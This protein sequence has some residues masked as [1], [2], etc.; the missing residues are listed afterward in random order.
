MQNA[1]FSS[2]EAEAGQ[3]LYVSGTAAQLT[4]GAGVTG[5][6]RINATGSLL[7]DAVYGGAIDG[8]TCKA[9]NAA[10]LLD[11]QYGDCGILVDNET[12]YV[13]TT[14]VVDKAGNA[15]WYASNAAAVAACGEN[16]YVKLFTGAPLVLTK[17]LYADLNGNKVDVSGQYTFY[18]MDSTGDSFSVPAGCAI[19]T[20]AVQTPATYAPDGRV[21]IAEETAEGY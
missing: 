12:M 1:A 19:L 18:G 11:G 16:S 17:D 3:D 7:T 21:Y 20:D 9:E 14:A 4:L 10:F 5:N 2:G 13:A 8:I 15:T 6:V